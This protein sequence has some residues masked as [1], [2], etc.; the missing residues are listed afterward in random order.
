MAPHSPEDKPNLERS[1]SATDSEIDETHLRFCEVLFQPGY[2]PDLAQIHIVCL[3]GLI[4]TVCGGAYLL[5]YAPRLTQL[6]L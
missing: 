6:S 1:K 4:S 3:K 2:S 5:D